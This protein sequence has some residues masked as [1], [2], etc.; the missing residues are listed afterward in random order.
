MQLGLRPLRGRELFISMYLVLTP[1]ALRL[2][3]LR[4]RTDQPSCVAHLE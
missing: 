1:Q 3:M 2:R 4:T